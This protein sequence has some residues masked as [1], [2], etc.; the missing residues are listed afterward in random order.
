M[1]ENI[2]SIS[3]VTPTRCGNVSNSFYFGM[4]LYIIVWVSI[5]NTTISKKKMFNKG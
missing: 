3:I 2:V 1:A 5:N 4:T